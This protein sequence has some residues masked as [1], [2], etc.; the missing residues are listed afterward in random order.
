[1]VQSLLKE[2]VVLRATAGSGFA[3]ESGEDYVLHGAYGSRFVTLRAAEVAWRRPTAKRFVYAP[4]FLLNSTEL[5]IRGIG[6]GGQYWMTVTVPPGTAPGKYTGSVK[7]TRVKPA[8]GD[9]SARELSVPVALTVRDIALEEADAAFF[10]WYH[11]S[12][13]GDKQMGP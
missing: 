8:G 13:V 5:L 7:I 1:Y 10:T 4:K 2:P 3:S 11:T 9:A 6:H 12:P